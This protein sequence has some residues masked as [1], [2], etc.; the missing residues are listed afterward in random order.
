M[1]RKVF[2]LKN[3]GMNRDLSISKAGESNA[4]TNLNVRILAR[5]KD[6]LLSITNEQG[7]TELPISGT[8]DG[9]YLVGWD[10]LNSY[11][12][13]FLTTPA[14]DNSPQHDYIYRVNFGA[15]GNPSVTKLFPTAAHP[16][17]DNLNF[18]IDNPIESLTYYEADTIQKIY[19]IDGRNPL[20]MM[21]FMADASEMA[22]WDSTYF[23]STRELRFGVSVNISKDNSGNP[24]PNGTIQ[25]LLTYYNKH[26][27]ETGYAWMSDL[28]YL[29]PNE[30]GGAADE[31]NNNK[32][33][34]TLSD[35]D[36]RYTHYRVYSILRTSYN[37]TVTSYI[38]AEG[39]TG[40]GSAI[41]VDDSANQ[42][43]V[44]ATDLLYLGSQPVRPYTMTQKDETLF[45]G[46][47]QLDGHDYTAL[48][49]A[50]ET[51]MRD[52]ETGNCRDGII[53]FEYS[54]GADCIPYV[55]GIG[56]YPYKNQLSG[57]SSEITTFKG[58]E[59]YRFALSFRTKGGKQTE[60]FW[61][62]DAVNPLYPIIDTNVKMLKRVLVRCD[63]PAEVIAVIRSSGLDLAVAQLMIAEAS[64]ADR[65]IKAQGV[66]NPTMFNIWSRYNNRLFAIPSW[67]TRPRNSAIANRHFSVVHNAVKST[68]EIECN[69]WDTEETPT[70]YYTYKT[71]DTQK[72]YGYVYEGR[73]EVDYQMLIIGFRR[74]NSRSGSYYYCELYYIRIANNAQD[75]KH[76]KE[77]NFS[78]ECSNMFEYMRAHQKNITGTYQSGG[79]TIE[80]DFNVYVDSI[81]VSAYGSKAKDKIYISLKEKAINE[82][83]VPAGMFI[84]QERF[85]ARFGHVGYVNVY[86]DLVDTSIDL[87]SSPVLAADDVSAF[88][89]QQAAEQR[90]SG[91]TGDYYSSFGGATP[92]YA[93]QHLMF[94]DENIVTLNSPE[95]FY[96]AISLDSIENHKLRIVGV[97]KISSC[98]SDYEV[99]ATHAMTPGTNLLSVSFSGEKRENKTSGLQA[100]PLW[101]EYGLIPRE[102]TAE[103]PLPASKA[104]YSTDDYTKVGGGI[105]KYWLH[106]FGRSG[107]IDG[108]TDKD[109]NSYGVLKHK[110]FANLRFAY[111]TVYNNA[112]DA[113]G[114]RVNDWE[115]NL[116]VVRLFNYPS[117]QI[118]TLDVGKHGETPLNK[119]SYDADIDEL[120]SVPGTL[121]YPIKY[122]VGAVDEEM[123]TE[124]RLSYMFSNTPISLKYSSNP[125]IVMAFD[126]EEVEEDSLL[127]YKQT[128]LP[129]LDGEDPI[130]I[131]S[132]DLI[133]KK[134]G[135]LLPWIDS[136]TAN[137]GQHISPGVNTPIVIGL[138]LPSDKFTLDNYG[139]IGTNASLHLTK[140]NV[141]AGDMI[142]SWQKCMQEFGGQSFFARIQVSS[143]YPEYDDKV[144]LVEISKYYLVGSDVVA[145]PDAKVVTYDTLNESD[146]KLEVDYWSYSGSPSSLTRVGYEVFAV[147][148][149]AIY[150]PSSS[151]P[152]LDYK[153]ESGPESIFNLTPDTA[154]GASTVSP[155]DEY[156][157]IGEVYYP[158]GESDGNGGIIPDTRYGDVKNNRFII[159]G[160]EY[161][162]DNMSAESGDHNYIIGNQGDTYF[163]RWDDMRIKPYSAEEV[164]G[165]VDIVSVMLETHINIDGRT[166]N[167]RGTKYIASMNNEQFDSLNTAYS[168]QNN[169]VR[170]K[171]LDSDFNLETYPSHITW[172]LPKHPMAETD[173]W[174]HLTLANTLALDGDKGRCRALRRYQNN[175]L[176]FQDRSISEILFNSRTQLSTTS[177]VPV[178]LAN[179]G[180][181]DGKRVLSNNY[182]CVNKW[183]IIE[184]KRA[185]YF[186]DGL[187]KKFCSFNGEGIRDISS[188]QHF[189][190]LFREALSYH[191]GGRAYYDKVYSDVYLM[192][193]YEDGHCLVYNE[194]VD[195]FTTFLGYAD[196]PMMTNIEDKFYSFYPNTQGVNK[197]WLQ[198]SGYF[199]NFF[200]NQQGFSVLYN[201]M[202]DPYGDKIWTNLEYRADFYKPSWQV[203]GTI[204]AIREG[205]LDGGEYLDAHNPGAY[206]PNE[207]FNNLYI[208]NE[209]QQ[210]PVFTADQ[211]KKK[212]R[213]WRTDVPRAIKTSTNKHA[214]D[215]IRNPWIK[216]YMGKTITG[217]EKEDLMQLHDVNVIYYE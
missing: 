30:S 176:A 203:G 133:N 76:I 145:I 49:T 184:G 160:P 189:D 81:A 130:S 170:A 5:D 4:Y 109:G 118:L 190:V 13:L 84:S 7:N 157:F 161:I 154:N 142:A 183:S 111:D 19:W 88:T 132:R 106:M 115:R 187:N 55:D 162:I 103:N 92:S 73:P 199:C 80:Y 50:I 16:T 44:D 135:A 25:Y 8:I 136:E 147:G 61:I 205:I 20:R 38:V 121:K 214:L 60:A 53:T 129:R 85:N 165:V 207:T 153:V 1:E 3:L 51:Y 11:L 21:N 48:E 202:P 171:D 141:D 12:I 58:N 66:I 180:K 149:G 200:G 151:Y 166:D 119:V 179:S 10:V 138:S 117:S 99:E 96:N 144:F 59:K 194:T 125:H 124:S 178:E 122:N 33:T 101:N 208:W 62:G 215:R 47:L 82:L 52:P 191:N 150:G 188:E 198:N 67:T 26:G 167:N 134:T 40:N 104:D 127:V 102:E 181:V 206:I 177:G 77:L 91:S 114:N 70:P 113:S 182:G 36:T 140:V 209:Y 164:N 108:Y 71:Y 148:N 128:T 193:D 86:A 158:F 156:V 212:F 192:A 74:S 90:W 63:I 211:T 32:I 18:S 42:V 126:T 54:T 169:Y 46:D 94:V 173:N 116:E 6:T 201:V 69:Y 64:Y 72:E 89:G 197:L 41:V 57:T 39:S 112:F 137:Q 68:G 213:I 31:N 83:Q 146:N 120:I 195:K 56:L 27:Q 196:V 2:S 14:Q 174:M 216:L 79:Q 17:D 100:W 34:L 172:T 75:T 143:S 131:P 105:I 110:V 210:T 15:L 185:L 29:S 155:T 175:I 152:Y 65:S 97:A 159:A 9:E 23:D 24:R 37:G 93:L 45:L 35:L 22:K 139:G 87:Q 95:V 217:N 163:Q 186:I 168:Q 28:V 98:I 204:Y 43:A 107:A 78:N 123:T